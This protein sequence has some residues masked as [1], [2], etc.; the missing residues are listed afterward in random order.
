MQIDRQTNRKTDIQKK[1]EK[2]TNRETK[3][4]RNAKTRKNINT[5]KKTGKQ[6]S[7]QTN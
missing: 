4:H 7:D 1:P 6:K 2:L 5:Q 3:R